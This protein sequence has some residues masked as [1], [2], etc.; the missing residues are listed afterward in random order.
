MAHA[1]CRIPACASGRRIDRAGAFMFWLHR[2]AVLLVFGIPLF[3]FLFSLGAF[4]QHGGGGGGQHGVGGIGSHPASGPDVAPEPSFI[5]SSTAKRAEDEGKVEFKSDV[6]LVQ[7]PVVIVDK[8]GNHIP[9]LKKEDFTLLESGKEQK[10]TAFEEVTANK[11]PLP[12]PE[13][14]PGEFHNAAS[15]SGGQPRSVMVVA[16]DT[17]NTP[18]L[19]QTYGRREL[20]KFLAKNLDSSQIFGLVVISSRGLSIIHGLTGNSKDLI[21]ALNKVS[22]EQP[23]MTGISTDAQVASVTGDPPTFSPGDL[24]NLPPRDRTREFRH[25]RRCPGRDV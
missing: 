17:L 21:E 24:G 19:D 1:G 5:P 4:A 14:A 25:H 6:V 8:A 16:L 10:I 13:S 18:M 22:S 2:H 7:V 23:A 12:A 11:S 15:A 20:L 9:N 3:S